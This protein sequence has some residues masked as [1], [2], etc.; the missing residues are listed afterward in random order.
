MDANAVVGKSQECQTSPRIFLSEL[1][2]IDSNE[3][4]IL[5]LRIVKQK[6]A[7]ELNKIVS[8]ECKSMNEV[9]ELKDEIKDYYKI[10]EAMTLKHASLNV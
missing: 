4:F 10:L 3:K 2:E 7:S 8:E 1:A 9:T 6:K 5:E